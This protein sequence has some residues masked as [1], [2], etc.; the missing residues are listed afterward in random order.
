MQ[1]GFTLYT[2]R[3]NYDQAREASILSGSNLIPLFNQL[4]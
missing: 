2:N 1:A 4:G 3:F